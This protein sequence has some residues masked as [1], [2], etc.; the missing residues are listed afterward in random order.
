MPYKKASV[1]VCASISASVGV[2]A[3]NVIVSFKVNCMANFICIC[4]KNDRNLKKEIKPLL[5]V[6]GSTKILTRISFQQTINIYFFFV[7]GASPD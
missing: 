3:G 7:L 6:F 1:E 5:F 4:Q 2:G